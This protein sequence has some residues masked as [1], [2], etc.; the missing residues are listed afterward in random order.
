MKKQ[1]REQMKITRNL[2]YDYKI[3]NRKNESKGQGN[4]LEHRVEK[5]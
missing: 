4:I 2:K 1:G 5:R 3:F